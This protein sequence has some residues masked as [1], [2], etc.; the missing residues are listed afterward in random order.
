[1]EFKKQTIINAQKRI[2]NLIHNTP[3][4]SS[5]YMNKISGA[6]MVFKCENFQKIG[7]F[8]MRGALN[9][10][11]SHSSNDIKKGFVTHSSGNH[12][13]AVALSSKI[14][15]SNAYI[16]MPKNAPKIKINAV[17]GY[18]ADITLCENNERARK[19][20]CEQLIK[21]TGANFIHPFDN[22]SVIAG[23]ATC[24]KEIYDISPKLHLD[25]IVCPVGGG[26]LASGT[27]LSTKF[28]SPKTKV[29]LA[30][31]KNA[32]DA[33]MSF[34]EK[35]LIPVKNPK[36]IADGLMTSLSEKTFNI[37]VKGAEK[38]ITVSEDEIVFAMKL[39]W[40]R[41]KIICEPSCAVP[42]AA[43]LKTKKIFKNKKVG[44]ILTGGNVDLQNLPF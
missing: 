25:Y 2:K 13:Q 33:Y 10:V 30:E 31:P 41:M 38:I 23:Q 44:I 18:G 40:E 42:L 15:K 22:D 12:A 7:A 6:N 35:K 34:N 16:V 19:E 26:G 21:R 17:K 24:S 1:M 39:I 32:S 5:E 11:M 20:S 27:I 4:L 37:I 9:A 14:M 43:V 28:F 29:I 3:V 8:K 36:T